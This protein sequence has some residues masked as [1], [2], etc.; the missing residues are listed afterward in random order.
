MY[1]DHRDRPTIRRTRERID[2]RDLV[3]EQQPKHE[4]PWAAM[5]S[6]AAKIGCS[7]ERSRKWVRQGKHDVGRCP[8]V[9]TDEQA[10]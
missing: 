8:G 4:S 2:R 6:V 3:R 5:T 7:G 9:T 1:D 10:R